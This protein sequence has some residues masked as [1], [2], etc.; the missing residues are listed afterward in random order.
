MIVLYSREG[1]RSCLMLRKYLRDNDIKHIV[2]NVSDANYS[3]TRSEVQ[4]LMKKSRKPEFL[5][6]SRTIAYKNNPL[7]LSELTEER[8]I[9]Y[10][11]SNP[12]CLRLPI[13][14]TARN[15]MFGWSDEKWE[16]FKR[17]EKLN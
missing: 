11:T 7:D 2:H 12:T 13:M 8:L 9:R 16:V 15:I 6:S 4:Y 3:I 10:I 17:K 1:C 14:L 5:V